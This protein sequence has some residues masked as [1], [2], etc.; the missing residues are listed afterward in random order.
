MR[1]LGGPHLASRD[2][3]ESVP[4][5]ASLGPGSPHP[6]QTWWPLCLAVLGVAPCG[7][8]ALTWWG[9]HWLRLLSFI[10]RMGGLP[11]SSPA[12]PERRGPRLCRERLAA[13]PTGQRSAR[14]GQ[15]V[16][17][18]PSP[19]EVLG[20]PRRGW[21]LQCELCLPRGWSGGRLVALPSDRPQVSKALS[22]GSRT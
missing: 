11:S 10:V 21:E 1:P 4:L 5:P 9:R 18:V 20:R 2:P 12:S 8:A 16:P 15:G 7:L 3:W 19:A 13:R 17:R 22:S 14:G 6:G